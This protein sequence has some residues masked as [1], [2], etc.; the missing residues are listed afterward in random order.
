MVTLKVAVNG[1]FKLDSQIL[2]AVVTR[3]SAGAYVLVNV[4][5]TKAQRVGRSD[6]DVNDRLHNWIGKYGRFFFA[7]ASSRKDAFEK[8]CHLYHDLTPP[9][10]VIHP[11]R[12]NGSGWKCPRCYIFD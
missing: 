1:P 10:N 12:P 6:S 8:E 9:D 4:Y 3:T 7:Y 11:D 5:D 2:N